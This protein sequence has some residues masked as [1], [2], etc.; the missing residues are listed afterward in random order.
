M[1]YDVSALRAKEFPWTLKGEQT[2]L[3]NAKTGA[4]PASGVT[5]LKRW[6]DL[7]AEPF[8]LTTYEDLEV[9][10]KTREL[11]AK[12]IGAKVG[13]IACMHNTSYGIN[14][15]SLCLPLK[16][17]HVVLTYEGEYPADVYPWMSLAKK[18]VKLELI[19]KK[20]GLQ[21]EERLLEELKRPEVRVVTMS[22]V[23]FS[24]GFRADL[25]TIGR[26]C[27]KRGIY[28]VVD[29]IQGVG[30]TTLD[31]SKLEIDVLACGG[32]KWLLA[33]WG[34][35]FVY[36]R[37]ELARTLD[38]AVVGWLAMKSSEDF[39]R[40]VDYDFKYYDDA[41]RFQINTLPAQDFAALNASLEM[42]FA[43]GPASVE[44]HIE[45]IV[46]DA[47]KWALANGDKVRL[48]TPVDPKKRA[49]VLAIAPRDPKGASKALSEAKVFHSLRE[50]AIRLSPHCFNTSEEMRRAL[51]VL[52]A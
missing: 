52:G 33:P 31:M 12:L 34:S 2:F 21:D 19:P 36:V 8:R 17:G 18:G 29:A 22:W 50:G 4:L 48:V 1:S 44:K 40:M 25:A 14:V 10:L 51:D 35:G 7:R 38:P 6:A 39:T 9:F 26:E 49:G 16:A 37:E 13:E 30:A 20:N 3:D 32:Q 15:A 28:F 23:S 46:S 45:G 27:R 43:L 41:R 47:V 42:F 24:T 11:V 5:A